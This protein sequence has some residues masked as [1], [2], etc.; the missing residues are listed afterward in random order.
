MRVISLLFL[1]WVLVPKRLLKC[2][3]L[4]TWNRISELKYVTY[5]PQNR[6]FQFRLHQVLSRSDDG[7]DAGG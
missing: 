1:P 7:Y 2:E 4:P 3:H 6:N 5:L